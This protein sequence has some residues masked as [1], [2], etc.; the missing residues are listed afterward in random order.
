[1]GEILLFIR[2]FSTFMTPYLIHNF[3]PDLS[4]V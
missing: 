1:M 3:S 2:G 4:A